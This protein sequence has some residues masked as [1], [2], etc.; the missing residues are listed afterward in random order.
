MPGCVHQHRMRGIGGLI[1]VRAPGP[2]Q[3]VGYGSPVAPMSPW[4]RRLPTL[5][6]RHAARATT[7][8][9][10][11]SVASVPGKLN[12]RNPRG[13][14]SE[15]LDRLAA[16]TSEQGP[17]LLGKIDDRA[18][19]ATGGPQTLQARARHG[20]C[21]DH[22]RQPRSPRIGATSRPKRART[23]TTTRPAASSCPRSRWSVHRP[24]RGTAQSLG[25]SAAEHGAGCRRRPCRR[26][27]RRWC[28][29]MITA[30][31]PEAA[32]Q[33]HTRRV[34]SRYS[35]VSTMPT[36]NQWS[37]VPG[38]GEDFGLTDRIADAGAHG[39][40]KIGRQL[41]GR[42][43]ACI[44]RCRAPNCSSTR[45]GQPTLANSAG[46]ERNMLATP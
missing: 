31:R 40:R 18:A 43:C 12:G 25:R 44:S 7:A 32:P 38:K 20:S 29:L 42:R 2:W 19:F 28:E 10:N 16:G 21:I 34:S 45:L 30:Q 4:S 26:V 23:S 33:S 14:H 36:A 41:L 35:A 22:C 24:K 6:F 8:V 39:R 27:G 5:T 3:L 37:T 13:D 9:L 46:I 11:G 17:G 1:T 15:D